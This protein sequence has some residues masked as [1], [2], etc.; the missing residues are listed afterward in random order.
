[1]NFSVL[2]S[3]YAKEKPEYLDLSLNSLVTQTLMPK[4]IVIVK[5]GVLPSELDE[6][7]HKYVQKYPDLF[8]IV[9]LKIN[10]GLGNALNIGLQYCDYELVARMDSDDISLP[11]R[12]E[13]QIYY[14][15]KNPEISVLGAYIDEF[16][17]EPT[18]ITS[19]RK[20]PISHDEIFKVAKRRNP[21]N[22][23]TVVFRKEFVMA[24]GGYRHFLWNEDYYLWVRMLNK[25]YKFANLPESLVLVR[26]GDDLFKRRGGVKYFLKEVELQK[27]FYDLG[28]IQFYDFILNIMLRGTIRLVPNFLRKI[29]YQLFL[30]DN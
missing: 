20:V 18:N 30:R 1:M 14:L 19:V 11:N 24:A 10:Q 21:L 12:F 7:I 17:N 13:K 2:M 29:I 27:K 9:A 22:H 26:A 15:H 4:E 23:M 6:V 5:D 8:K 28:F 16:E 3:V 25:G